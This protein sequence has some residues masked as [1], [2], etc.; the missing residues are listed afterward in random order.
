MAFHDTVAFES[1]N[2][3]PR[4]LDIQELN[5]KYQ[6]SLNVLQFYKDVLSQPKVNTG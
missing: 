2:Q 6:C 4:V 3:C 1:F 5:V